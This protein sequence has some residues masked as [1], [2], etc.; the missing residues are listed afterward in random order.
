MKTISTDFLNQVIMPMIVV[1]ALTTA[2]MIASLIAF[3]NGKE[4][5]RVRGELNSTKQALAGRKRDPKDIPI[6]PKTTKTS[7]S[8]FNG[9][10][11]KEIKKQGRGA[12]ASYNTTDKM[13]TFENTE[14]ALTWGIGILSNP[15]DP[16][17]MNLAGYGTLMETDLYMALKIVMLSIL[18]QARS[19]LIKENKDDSKVNL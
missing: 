15:E 3:L 9:Y 8:L 10:V 1:I 19:T 13:P 11:S 4:L 16:T 12:M 18:T 7:V 2:F 5:K 17:V 6:E 14:T